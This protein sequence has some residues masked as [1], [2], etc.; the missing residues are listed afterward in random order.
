MLRPIMRYSGRR[1]QRKL[2]KN[3]HLK[4]LHMQ[5][6]VP[7]RVQNVMKLSLYFQMPCDIPFNEDPVW[8]VEPYDRRTEI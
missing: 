8:R 4:N 7:V 2:N 5:L 6:G 1:M 3:S